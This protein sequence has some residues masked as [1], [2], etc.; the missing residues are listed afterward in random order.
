MLGKKAFALIVIIALTSLDGCGTY[1]P[2]MEEAWEAVDVFPSMEHKIKERIFCETVK[3]LRDVNAPLDKGGVSFGG[4]QLIPN[5][6]GVQMQINLT[7]EEI[8][9]LNPSVG[10]ADTLENEI[11]HKITV[12]QSFG[13]NGAATLSSTATRT[14]TTYSYYNVGKITAQGAEAS[15]GKDVLNGSSPLLNTD[16]G[17]ERFL[18]DN[19]TGAM[20]FS[21]SPVAVGGAGKSAKLDV[22]S[23]EIKFAVVTNASLN[24]VWKL[25]NLT[26]GAGSLPLVNLGRTRTHDLI[27]TF[28]PGTN[29]PVD[30]ALQT[31]FTNQIVQSNMR[32]LQVIPQQVQ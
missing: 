25:Y 3:A 27:L 24:P 32:Q 4:R 12:G 11:I 26:A 9:A 15:C 21:S 31:H 20:F 19:A 7:V 8:G 23:Y 16:L 10:F 2:R 18:R 29:G 13:L 17:I 28:G 14:D 5:D 22:F 30:F 1:V 6:F